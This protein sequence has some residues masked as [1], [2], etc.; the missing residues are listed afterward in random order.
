MPTLSI[1]MVSL[2]CR[3]VVEDC[4]QS[5]RRGSFHDL[6]IIIVDNGSVDGT[7]DYLRAQADVRLIENG[8]NAGFTKGTNQGINAASGK[9][10][11]WLNTDTV[12]REDS[13][14][15]LIA[16]LE[17]SARAGIAGPKVL[18]AD[19]TFQ[20]QCKRG[21][22]TPFASF[23]YAVGL[24]RIWPSN[25]AVSRY[26]LR[27]I[28]EDQSSIVDAVSGCCLL[29]RRE[30]FDDIGPLD[31]EMF[32]FGEDLDWCVRAAKAGW[33]VWYYPESVI[34]H[35][36]G[37]GGAHS[38]PYRMIS[39]MHHCMWVFYRKHVKPDSSPVT[40]ALVAAGV[41]ASFALSMTLQYISRLVHRRPAAA[42]A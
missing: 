21:F 10:L 25:P 39:A 5:I 7:L 6:E 18:N 28:P 14:Q 20:P 12:L 1:C 33:E 30:V 24:D 3:R 34:V 31:E 9:Y 4:L 27:S 36:K 42:R 17:T 11:L 37:Q 23:C 29:A 32:G 35:L 26:L 41:A 22:P 13:L 8:Y 15:K 40:T 19:G 2:D 16:F 38:K